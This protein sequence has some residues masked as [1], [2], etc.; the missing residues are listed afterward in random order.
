M[1]EEVVLISVPYTGTNFTARLFT[2]SG[3]ERI[4]YLDKP[5]IDKT[6]YVGHMEKNE[7]INHA[8]SLCETRPLI[9]P[10]RH[11][12]RCEESHR[13]LNRPVAGMVRAYRTL[14][15]RILPLKPY[16]MAV[17]SGRKQ[18]CFESLRDIYPKLKPPI[19]DEFGNWEV[20]GCKAGTHEMPWAD[21]TPSDE[22]IS[23]A[24]DIKPFLD[25]Y[26]P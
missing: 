20:V 10:L 2:E 16:I 24:E 26:Y 18:E 5:G 17:D 21:F 6:I 12:Y 25:Q 14:I 22:V 19:A 15:T 1:A 8:L 3:F 7:Q 4:G 9:C 23:L 11:P 13:R